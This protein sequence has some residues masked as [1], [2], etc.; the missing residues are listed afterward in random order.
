MKTMVPSLSLK[1]GGGL[2]F[3]RDLPI[4]GDPK[5]SSA[6]YFWEDLFEL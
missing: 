2:L 1:G 5:K 4:A 6:G 3:Y